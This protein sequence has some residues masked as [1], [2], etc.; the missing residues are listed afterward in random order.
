MRVD[1]KKIQKWFAWLMLGAM[2]VSII[3][4]MT[5]REREP[6]RIAA[7]APNSLYHELL[8]RAS[9][10]IKQRTGRNVCDQVSYW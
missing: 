8:S 2:V 1:T 4:W 3:A 5:S 6:I 7:G 10:L 9:P